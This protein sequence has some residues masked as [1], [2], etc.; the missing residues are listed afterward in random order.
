MATGR[1]KASTARAKKMP[2]R[3]A[4]SQL[5]IDQKQV[6]EQTRW[7]CPAAWLALKG[8]EQA[9]ASTSIRVHPPNVAP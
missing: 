5:A 9:V 6:S 8:G 1:D 7:S 3:C 4:L 2:T